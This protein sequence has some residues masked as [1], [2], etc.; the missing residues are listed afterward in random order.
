MHLLRLDA[1]SLDEGEAAVDLAQEL[2]Q[3]PGDVVVLSFTDSDLAGLAGAQATRP[4]HP[5]LRLAPLRRL[6]H[7][8]SVDLY[9]ERVIAHARLVVV[10]CLGGLD[11]WRYG[12]EAVARL[13]R[14]QGIPLA[15]LPGDDRPD[16]RL[17]AL[18]TIEAGLRADLDACFRA[19]G[20][21]NLGRLLDRIAETLGHAIKA[22]PA[23]DL[24]R[25]FAWCRGCGPQNLGAALAA[26]PAGAP[27]ALL[28]VYRSA[29]LAQ[30]ALPAAA[31]AAALEARGL[32]TLTL[33]VASLKDP[34]TD[35]LVRA[36]LAARRPDVILTTTAF[37][38]REDAG[39]ALDAADCPVLQATVVG[40]PR[41]AWAASS[42]GLSAADLAMQVVLPEF[43]GRLATFPIAFK[44]AGATDPAR[45]AVP[46]AQGLAAVAERALAWVRLA[47]TPRAERRLALVLSDYPTRGGRAGFAVGLDTPASVSAILTLLRE[48]G[49]DVG[50][51]GSAGDIV[52]P[53]S[54]PR[55][56]PGSRAEDSPVTQ[57]PARTLSWPG[58]SRP[59]R[60]EAPRTSEDRD[61]RDKPGEDTAWASELLLGSASQD[62]A[63]ARDERAGP[64]GDATSLMRALTEGPAGFAVPLSAY[65]AWHDA[66]PEPVR[67]ALGEAWG[68]PEADPALAAD[69][70]RFRA[71]AFGNLRLALQPDRGRGADRKAGYHDPDAPPTH[72]Y[73]AF[74][75]GLREELGAHAL[76]QLGTHGTAE[77]LPGKA[78][79]LSQ[80]CFP[81]LATGAL[82]VVYPFIVDDPGEAA[83][84]KRR[85]GAVTL[86]HLTPTLGRAG[87]DP[88]AARLR[89]LVEEYAGAS[90]LDP[91]RADGLARDIRAEAGEAGLDAAAG[92]DADT[93]MADALTRLDAHLCD[94]AEM[95]VREGLHVFG[96]APA[97]FE[98]CA[99]GE[100]AGLL[101]ALDGRFVP[102]G[103]AGSP[104]RN[105][106]DV[107]PTGRNLATLDPRSLPTRAATRLG[108]LAADAVVRRHLQEEGEPPRRI[109]MDLWASPTL[110]TGGEDIAHALAL[111]G[112]RATWD[113]ASTRVNGFEVLPL[114]L[115]DRP[116]IDVTLR[117]SGAFRDTFPEQVALL[118]RAARTVA[119]RD[120]EDADNPLAAAR[121]RG[122]AL[123]R[124]YG[125]GPG[126][127]GAGAGGLALDG[128][129]SERDDLARAYLAATDHAFG[130]D[131]ASDPGFGARAAAADAFVHAFDAPGRDLLEGDAAAEAFGGLA[132]A[133]GLGGGA[134]ALYSLDVTDPDAPR[135]RT[136]REDAARVMR[137]R[138][139]NPGWIA[140]MLRHGWRGAAE[141]AQGVDAVFVLAATTDAVANADLDRLYG[142]TL[143]DPEVAERLAAANP[144]AARAIAA[145]LAELQRR[146]LWTSRRNAPLDLPEAA[147]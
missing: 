94:L 83:P 8:M 103:P 72:A 53:L 105:R 49:Y 5:S 90:V 30:D 43:D 78:V 102:P 146:G 35:A 2:G 81:A 11:Y 57:F 58:L 106:L 64:Q 92:I 25:A 66:L 88:S 18:S 95:A 71:L 74:H 33:A 80:D 26:L 39:F 19:G 109:V 51:K 27:F 121:R 46:D 84:A 79:A 110:R 97:G 135:V 28:L 111:M 100:R 10:R 14:A 131:E 12:A 20:Q 13:C 144:Q 4:A 129:W 117:I 54:R 96:A 145:R 15:L 16:P 139:A 24:P 37:S 59:S 141:I 126:R 52:S 127:Y 128:E 98:A 1:V 31:L 75:L 138:L 122:E 50:P 65:R 85:L 113:H 93:P 32:P 73:L 21:D 44:E 17:D 45:R 87:L 47:R 69:A 118:D 133:A 6:R 91:R 137:A 23:A 143:G 7:P 89:A 77:W 62:D 123:A 147:E 36:L 119:A 134:P 107:L 29:V 9:V 120:E 130:A 42:R 140:G 86:G 82:P 38:A 41:A 125:A 108:T 61:H 56:D 22:A 76:I 116:R 132:A 34:A 70:F 124:V 104:T 136:A 63:V 142:A 115:L 68:P 112:M 60:S 48:A 55:P 40:A 99:A 3:T 67:T 114:A 101:A